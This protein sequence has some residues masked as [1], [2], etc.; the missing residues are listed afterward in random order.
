M[1]D[2]ISIFDQLPNTTGPL[3]L[4]LSSQFFQ[5]IQELHAWVASGFLGYSPFRYPSTGHMA[6]LLAIN[7]CESPPDLY[8][9][10]HATE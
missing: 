3:P 8:E 10:L 1:T 2:F 9:M 7:L 6:M 5:K 4:L